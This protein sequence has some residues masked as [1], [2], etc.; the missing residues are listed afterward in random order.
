MN[1]KLTS[2]SVRITQKNSMLSEKKK[3]MS[4]KI[5][6]ESDINLNNID[7]IFDR[8]NNVLIR[9]NINYTDIYS[10]HLHLFYI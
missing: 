6:L 4:Y 1:K 2:L 5:I 9:R 7:S 8:L 3:R 10:I